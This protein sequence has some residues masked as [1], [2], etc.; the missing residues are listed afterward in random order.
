VGLLPTLLA[1]CGWLLLLPLALRQ[2]RPGLVLALPLLGLLSYLYFG[3]SYP[4]VDGGTLKTSFM[5]STA[6]GW[7]LGFGAALDR[8]RARAWGLT[9]ALLTLCALVN[10]TFVVYP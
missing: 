2:P 1:V 9:A 10:L 7:A 3:L 6:P 8:L 4:T 5:L